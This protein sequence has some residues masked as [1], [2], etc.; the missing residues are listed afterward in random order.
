MRAQMRD[1]KQ[2]IKRQIELLAYV[3][4]AK[5]KVTTED[6]A[7]K[8]NCDAL[9]IKRDM[10]ELRSDGIE[11]HSISGKGLEIQNTIPTDKIKDLLNN[12]ITSAVIENSYKKSTSLMVNKTKEFSLVIFS[13][14]QQ[15]IEKTNKVDILYKKPD[16]K[17]EK[18]HQIEPMMIFESDNNWRVLAREE[19]K[20]KQFLLE[21]IKDI[22]VKELKFRKIPRIELKRI[23]E[24]SFKSW[25]GNEKYNI[26]LEVTEAWA[27]RLRTKQLMEFQ[28]ISK[29]PNGI[30]VFECT[31]NS[32]DEMASWI[33]GRGKGIKVVHPQELKELVINIAE[34]TLMNYNTGV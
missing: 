20:I 28:K 25:L 13:L 3:I 6:L 23:F 10:Q 24:T 12:Y 18:Y 32:L 27:E 30:I 26:K 29:D 2:K 1:L 11:I 5:D 22:S 16:D 21:R 17:S 9:T 19:D 33:A 8:F 7:Y 14:I 4:C 34:K 15:A 31:V